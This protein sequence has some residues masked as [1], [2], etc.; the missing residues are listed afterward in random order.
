[1]SMSTPSQS[2]ALGEWGGGEGG[3]GAPSLRDT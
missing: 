2:V 1:M 3:G